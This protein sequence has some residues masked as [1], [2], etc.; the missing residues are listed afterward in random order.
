MSLAEEFEWDGETF[1]F[2]RS[3]LTTE[4]T[5]EVG[6][7]LVVESCRYRVEFV[8]LD[9]PYE[10]SVWL[11]VYNKTDGDTP[12][13]GKVWFRCQF[14]NYTEFRSGTAEVS[15]GD[16]FTLAAAIARKIGSGH[17]P[18]VPVS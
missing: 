14:P 7:L 12:T 16:V 6:N 4:T 15:F 5:D 8:A 17:M 18:F 3:D 11:A 1:V 9:Q 13:H 2:L 10:A